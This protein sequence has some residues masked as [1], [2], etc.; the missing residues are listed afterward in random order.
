VAL[1]LAPDHGDAACTDTPWAPSA[2]CG[3]GAR[4]WSLWPGSMRHRSLWTAFNGDSTAGAGNSGGNNGGDDK[5]ESAGA[6]STLEFTDQKGNTIQLSGESEDACVESCKNADQLKDKKGGEQQGALGQAMQIGV[7]GEQQA[8]AEC[9]R[10]CQLE[11]QWYCFPGDSTVLVRGRGRVRL[12]ELRVGEPVLAI[13]RSPEQLAIDE[14]KEDR[15]EVVGESRG[16]QDWH[17]VM[18]P[19]CRQNDEPGSPCSLPLPAATPVPTAAPA[20]AA[21]LLGWELHFE[22]VL[23]FLHREPATEAEV[24]RIRHGLGQVH[25]TANHLLFALRESN[26]TI[27]SI[28]ADEV[29]VGDR[30]LAPWID[31]TLSSPEVQ[32]VDRVWKST[33]LYAPLLDSGTVLVDG[34]A[35]S[36]YAIP[37]NMPDAHRRVAKVATLQNAYHAALLPLRFFLAKHGMPKAAPDPRVAPAKGA[38]AVHPYVWFLY[39][40]FAS[41]VS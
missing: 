39:V 27:E 13:R 19:A 41:L 12:S 20:V 38:E 32:A 35:A 15:D 6:G 9:A 29:R 23:A 17:A 10:F 33:G 2:R 40:V 30:V 5:K 37:W 24:L 21:P 11:F 1:P 28:L 34:T 22:P 3:G 31:G 16:T 26:G 25:L 14:E 7:G 36:C 18:T 8:M 4:V